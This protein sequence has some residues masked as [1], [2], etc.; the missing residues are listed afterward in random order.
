MQ[1]DV[2]NTGKPCYRLR[3]RRAV[4]DVI[5]S[6]KVRVKFISCAAS[7]YEINRDEGKN[8]SVVLSQETIFECSCNTV[9]GSQSITSEESDRV[10][11][12]DCFMGFQCGSKF[13]LTK[14][15]QNGRL[16]RRNLYF[17]WSCG[18]STV[19]CDRNSLCRTFLLRLY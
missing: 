18:V 10:Y 3:V 5:P 7:S 6:D 11:C 2:P 1:A 15:R 14:Q 12:L 8:L 17:R 9:G 16:F 19:S 13:C 4:L